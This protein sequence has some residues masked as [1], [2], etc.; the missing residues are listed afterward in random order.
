[1]L[2]P[3]SDF[4]EWNAAYCKPG[5]ADNPCTGN[6]GTEIAANTAHPSGNW[7]MLSVWTADEIRGVQRT[8]Y[9]APMQCGKE[10]AWNCALDQFIML[11]DTSKD[12][13]IGETESWERNV[14]ILKDYALPAVT[15]ESDSF[16]FQRPVP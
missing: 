8:V 3:S 13:V 16:I 12:G 10:G 4:T 15:P 14:I 6:G 2:V 5:Q 7:Y 9:R 1:V 11:Y